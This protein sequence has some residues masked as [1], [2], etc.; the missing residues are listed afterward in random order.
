Q[1]YYV[2]EQ[3]PNGNWATIVNIGQNSQKTFNYSQPGAYRYRAKS[4][5]LSGGALPKAKAVEPLA[6]AGEM[7][8]AAPTWTCGSF[9]PQKVVTLEQPPGAFS[10]SGQNFFDEDGRF[11]V[12]W[13]TSSGTVTYYDVDKRKDNG[14]WSN[15]YSSGTATSNHTGAKVPFSEGL[16]EFRGR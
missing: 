11:Y 5:L 4:C 6:K 1:R 8:A 14:S 16:Y 7:V 10:F 15:F 9:G 3:R 12:N 13:N 2:E